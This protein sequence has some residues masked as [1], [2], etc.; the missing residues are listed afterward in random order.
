MPKVN[1]YLS[2]D[3]AAAVRGACIPVSTVC[4]RALEDALRHATS[5]R[6]GPRVHRGTLPAGIQ[7]SLTPSGRLI[8]TIFLGFD[9][10]RNRDHSFVG[11]EHLLLGMLSEGENLGVR[12]IA[13]LDV[14]PGDARAELEAVMRQA[15][16]DA[17]PGEP[18]LTP[19]ARRVID[20]MEKEAAQLRHNYLGCEH[21]L[22]ALIRESEGLAGQVLRRMG[23]DVAITR[24]A[25]VTALA[26]FGHGR[27]NPA[28]SNAPAI[29]DLV[30]DIGARLDY[31]ESRLGKS[32]GA[33]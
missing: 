11:T 15:I 30:R 24:R 1:V 22:L 32:G 19:G 2:D 8:H 13:A 23:L 5:L 10:A 20:L 31:L 21:L 27:A 33:A 9:E 4:Q 12:V 28:P 29:D 17:P 6:E 18:D 16:R 7:L 26:G 25:V 3:L 14:M